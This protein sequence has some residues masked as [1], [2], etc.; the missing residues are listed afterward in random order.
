MASASS[1]FTGTENPL[2]ESGVWVATSA[3][4]GAVRKANGLAVVNTGGDSARRYTGVTFAAD[5]YS[6]ITLASV[7][8]G[9]LLYFHYCMARM[10]A[11]AG[12]YLV[13]TAADVGPNIIQLY[14]IS[15]AGAFTQIGTDITTPSN[16]AANDVMR[17]EV[18]GTGLTVKWNGATLRTATDSTWASGQ[19]S[20][21][22][23]AQNSS[24]NVP[25][26][27]SW[28]AADIVTA[29]GPLPPTRGGRNP[30]YQFSL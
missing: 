9:G 15:N 29:G 20:T 5:H 23:W 2:S 12:C 10:N 22:G 4:W 13:T 6:E 19:P 30:S 8:S 3:Y 16:F 14:N 17:L 26:T 28:N 11:T 27:A 25:F 18:V 24:S 1:T 21:G 7:P